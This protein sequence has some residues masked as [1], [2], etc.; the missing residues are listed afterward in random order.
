MSYQRTNVRS[1]GKNNARD[2]SC[3]VSDRSW[4]DLCKF[5]LSIFIYLARLPFNPCHAGTIYM[6]GIRNII[7]ATD[8]P[9]P[10]R[11]RAVNGH[12]CAFCSER[13]I[14]VKIYWYSSKIYYILSKADDIPKCRLLFSSHKQYVMGYCDVPE[15]G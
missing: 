6:Q 3:A 8:A 1:F 4:A 14:S 12:N 11:R 13:Y 15:L 2:S 5:N 9:A 7:M 10:N